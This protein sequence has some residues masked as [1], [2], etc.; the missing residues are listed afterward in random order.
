MSVW[1]AQLT[2]KSGELTAAELPAGPS[3]LVGRDVTISRVVELLDPG[4]VVT[5]TGCGGVGKTSVA[6]EV[7]RV[8]VNDADHFSDGVWLC[9][10]GALVDGSSIPSAIADAIGMF[11]NEDAS[12]YD[13]VVTGLRG[14]WAVLVLDNCEHIVGAAAALVQRLVTDC[15][16]LAVLVTSREPLRIAAE[17]VVLVDPLDVRDQSQELFVQLARRADGGFQAADHVEAIDE[18]CRALDGVPLALEL[19]AARLGPMTAEDVASRLDERFRLLRCDDRQGRHDSLHATVAWSH[20]LLDPVERRLFDRLSVFQGGFDADAAAAILDPRD[21]GCDVRTVLSSLVEKS[22]ITIVDDDG[23]AAPRYDV[24]ESLRQF[25]DRQLAQHNERSMVRNEHLSHVVELT[26]A[27]NAFAMGNDWPEGRRRLQR[28]WGN[29]RAAV[30]WAI[31][32]TRVDDVDRLLRDV[33]FYCRWTLEAEAAVW[34][35]RALRRG[36]TTGAVPGAPVYLHVAFQQFLAGEHEDALATLQLGLQARGT[37][38]DRGWCRH[39]AAVELL[40]LGRAADAA[41]QAAWDVADESPRPV[42]SVMRSSSLVMFNT[43]ARRD[44]PERLQEQLERDVERAETTGNAVAIGHVT[45][46]R[47]LCAYYRGAVDAYLADMQTALEIA[48]AAGI[49]N[50]VGYVLTAQVYAPGWSGLRAS[51]DA[52]EYWSL[53][54]DI[55]NEF[56]V[57]EAVAINLA[58]LRHLEPAGVVLGNLERDRRKMASSVHRRKAALAE[59][60]L[61]RDSDEWLARGAAMSRADLL[62]FTTHCVADVLRSM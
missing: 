31:D 2:A 7:A 62:E 42:E 4:R 8:V 36:P 57:L 9:E 20:A 33:F 32:T 39:Y 60:R 17:D 52:L 18:I 34:A 15:P 26:A 44:D 47:A 6:F 13:S 58:E 16:D 40:Y 55:G 19:A 1:E 24:L 38:S 27:G 10:L 21:R 46:N 53:Q 49:V 5:L 14:L 56:V 23:P 45:Y 51:L 59:I 29:I 22:M 3:R 61:H 11:Q 30:N 37:P 43:Y 41:E 28:D 54:R 35:E 25:G 12:A 48:R 50:L